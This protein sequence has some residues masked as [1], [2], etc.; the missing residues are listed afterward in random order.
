MITDDDQCRKPMDSGTR[1]ARVSRCDLLALRNPS[2]SMILAGAAA[3]GCYP[4]NKHVAAATACFQAMIDEALNA[5]GDAA[6]S[7]PTTGR[8]YGK[9]TVATLGEPLKND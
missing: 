2:H 7:H 8:P 6:G 5:L 1:T 9:D 4:R 3:L